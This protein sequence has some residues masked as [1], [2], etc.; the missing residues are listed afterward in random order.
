M[1]VPQFSDDEVFTEISV[2]IAKIVSEA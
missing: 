1:I 2:L